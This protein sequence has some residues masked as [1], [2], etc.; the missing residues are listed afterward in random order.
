[1]N[2]SVSDVKYIIVKSEEEILSIIKKNESLEKKFIPENDK[3]LLI[4]KII[5][6]DNIF[7]DF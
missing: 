1:M 4:S 3:K 5:S 2:F 6:L 7:Q